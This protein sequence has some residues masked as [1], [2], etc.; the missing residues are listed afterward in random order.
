MAGTFRYTLDGDYS[1]GSSQDIA[2]AGTD[3]ALAASLSGTMPLSIGPGSDLGT[4]SPDFVYKLGARIAGLDQAPGGVPLASTQAGVLLDYSGIGY[5]ATFFG[6]TFGDILIGGTR[7][8]GLFGNAG[9]DALRGNEG[10]DVL[11]GGAGADTLEG[12]AGHD[13]YVVDDAGDAVVELAGE[14]IDRVTASIDYTLGDFVERLELTGAAVTG[15][16]NGLSNLLFGNAEDNTLIGMGGADR[17]DGGGG[18][19]GLQG[20]MGNDTYIVDDL[21]D[22]VAEGAGEGRDILHAYADGYALAAGAEVEVLFARVAGSLSGNALANVL[23]AGTAGNT[24]SGLGGDDRLVG[25]SAADV[26]TGG[27]GADI[28]IGGDGDDQLTGSLDSDRDTFAFDGDDGTDSI[29]G[30][31]A[32]QDVI[33]L[34]GGITSYTVTEDAVAG[35][36]TILAGDTTIEI[37]GV[38]GTPLL[39]DT[40]GV[41]DAPVAVDDASAVDEDGTVTLTLADILGNDIDAD[42]DTIV[43]QSLD[44]S[45]LSGTLT[46]NGDGTFTYDT[47]GAFDA[48]ASGESAL[49]SFTYTISDGAGGT[50]TGTVDIE[51]AGEREDFAGSEIR[52]LHLFPNAATA[53][54]TRTFE[55]DDD[56]VT[57]AYRAGSGVSAFVTIVDDQI[58]LSTTASS[59][60]FSQPSGGFHGFRI[61]DFLDML[62]DIEGVSLAPGSVAFDA[63]R[64]TFT[65]DSVTVE[66]G[67]FALGQNDRL[68]LDVD[69][70]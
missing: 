6:G 7:A 30:F 52:Y 29:T 48:L 22:T 27:T 5:R 67:N 34:T 25:G 38:F 36:T 42:G 14:G 58:I 19:D 64:L 13:L 10:S 53:N 39:I 60:G 54:S 11:D 3:G 18:A 56:G 33:L 70:A 9:N 26:L 32:A 49:D 47:N 55:V 61:E 41:N 65:D 62:P 57:F 31:D 28:L 63:S 45:G 2:A 20:G 50:D 69:F 8:D 68:I 24:L 16:G 12:G 59:I 15:T 43:L 23:R 66:I 51:V 1:E 44:T 35:T 40:K 46:D 17:L 21:G 4:A 37:D